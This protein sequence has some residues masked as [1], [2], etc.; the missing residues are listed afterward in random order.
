[1]NIFLSIMLA[2]QLYVAAPVVDQLAQTE[3]AAKKQIAKTDD[4]I[5]FFR[6]GTGGSGGTYYV[7]GGIIANAISNPPG[8]R[9]CENGGS[10]G[11]KNLIAVAQSTDGSLNN[12]ELLEKA[13]LQAAIVQEDMAEAAF[14]EKAESNLRV[15]TP[16]Y[17]DTLHIMVDANS[18][19]NTLEDLSGK[20]VGVGEEQSGTAATAQAL[21]KEAGIRIIPQ[22]GTAQSA[23]A[24][25]YDNNIDALII[26]GGYPIPIL[27]TLSEHKDIRLIPVPAKGFKQAVIP[28]NTYKNV[29]DTETLQITALLLTTADQPEELVYDITRAFWHPSSIALLQ[30]GHPTGSKISMDKVISRIAL[31]PA[32]PLHPGALKYYQ[33]ISI[34]KLIP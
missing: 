12:L 16:L 27:R 34:K 11:V 21:F 30:R 5:Q 9:A 22:Y 28:E 19:I 3:T 31:D 1:M 15:I 10:C 8:S 17:P 13:A 7:I 14:K 24:D 25:L 29:P 4:K 33:D 6:I 20:K 32:I 2:M 26:L 23:A 18:Q